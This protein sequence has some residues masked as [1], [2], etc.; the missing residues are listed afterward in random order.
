[1]SQ[2]NDALNDFGTLLESIYSYY[3][4]LDSFKKATCN[5]CIQNGSRVPALSFTVT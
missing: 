5:L 1:M 2:G 3:H 4:L